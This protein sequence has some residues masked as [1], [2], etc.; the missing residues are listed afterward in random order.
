MAAA[1]IFDCDTGR[2][3]EPID[4]GTLA[5]TR[6]P[7]PGPTGL[8]GMAAPGSPTLRRQGRRGIPVA[9]TT[10]QRTIA[11]SLDVVNQGSPIG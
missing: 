10:T 5:R 1:R 4:S 11:I 7:V 3:S 2:S 6:S 9:P 8:S